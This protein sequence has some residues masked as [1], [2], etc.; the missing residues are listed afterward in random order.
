LSAVGVDFVMLAPS[1]LPMASAEGAAHPRAWKD[2]LALALVEVLEPA[3]AELEL[4]TAGDWLALLLPV[5]VELLEPPPLLHA[6][7]IIT[8]TPPKTSRA[9]LVR[10][11]SK[12]TPIGQLGQRQLRRPDS[13]PWCRYEAG[14]RVANPRAAR[15]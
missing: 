9:T 13:S 15:G 14:E 12:N 3:L 7:A 11:P 4:V 1:A 6:A 10:M 2:P 8:T 5:A